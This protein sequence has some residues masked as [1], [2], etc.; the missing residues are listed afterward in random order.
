MFLLAAS[1]AESAQ[2]A[3]A[4]PAL[5]QAA[6]SAG[7]V[8]GIVAA[9]LTTIVIIELIWLILQNAGLSGSLFHHHPLRCSL[10]PPIHCE[11]WSLPKPSFSEQNTLSFLSGTTL[12]RPVSGIPQGLWSV[13]L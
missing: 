5:S 12:P 1:Q 9:S 7:A 10:L 2:A 6:A 3:A 11:R 13:L 8:G 4:D